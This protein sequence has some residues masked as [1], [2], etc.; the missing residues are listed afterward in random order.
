MTL[1]ERIDGDV[2]RSMKEGDALKLSVLRMALSAIKSLMIDKNLKTLD[3]DGV[4]QILQ[5]QVKQHR[6]S[7]DQ[8]TKGGRSD[9]ADKEKAELKILEE[10]LPK[11]MSEEEVAAVIKAAMAE[12]GA[13]TKADTG[14]VMKV[15]M[16][17]TKGK[18]DGK[19]VN[20][21]VQQLLK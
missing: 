8:F 9:L 12:T 15:I 3:D 17:K 13:V 19:M 5:R 4:A 11:Q 21:M 1:Y 7:I 6:E 14:K 2:K 10:Y 20:Q 18:A 16:E